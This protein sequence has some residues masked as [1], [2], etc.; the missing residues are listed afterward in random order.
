MVVDRNGYYGGE[1]ASLNLTDLYKKFMGGE[2]PQAEFFAEMGSGTGKAA[3]DRDFNV[4]LIPKFI[5]AHGK[6]NRS[7]GMGGCME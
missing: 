7:L 2:S 4:D 3:A 1:A 5:M 6:T